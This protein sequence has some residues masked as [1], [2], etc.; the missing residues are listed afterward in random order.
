MLYIAPSYCRD[1]WDSCNVR[2][3]DYNVNEQNSRAWHVSKKIVTILRHTAPLRFNKYNAPMDRGGWMP[4]R[5]LAVAIRLS[6]DDTLS[7]LYAMSK[8][9][10]DRCQV[11]MLYR[12]VVTLAGINWVNEGVAQVRACQGHSIPWIFLDRL[13]MSI[14]AD[15][16]KD[17]PCL[18]HGTSRGA[19]RI[20]LKTR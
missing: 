9:P 3:R 16:V 11:A 17:L 2:W 20:S 4:I 15:R 10:K 14:S 1:M 19:W 12:K 13:G 7:M 6:I 8:D 5:D 18:C